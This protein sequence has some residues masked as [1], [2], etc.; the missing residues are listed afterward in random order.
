MRP[1]PTPGNHP[2]KLQSIRLLVVEDNLPYLYLVERA[3][4]GR[5]GPIRWEL[6]IA[7]DGEEALRLLFAEED[8]NGPLPDLILLDWS[9]PKVNGD[10]VLRRIKRH[11]KLR[12][13]PVLVFS[14]SE[15]DDDIDAAYD[16]HANGYIM[17]PDNADVLAAIVET[18]EQFWVTVA[19]LPKVVR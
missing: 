16:N 12:R 15:A 8:R 3:F 11:S 5:Q 9:L 7:Q 6:T 14:G 1:T 13:I 10:E 4:R 2:G 19:H 18:M 17:K